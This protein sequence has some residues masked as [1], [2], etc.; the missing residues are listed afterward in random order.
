MIKSEPILPLR[1]YD[2][3]FDQ[4]RFNTH[5]FNQCEVELIYPPTELPSFQ[6]T[7]PSKFQLPTDFIL[8]NVCNDR[9]YSL[10][11]TI[12]ESSS[13]FGTMNEFGS[14]PKDAI[15][16]D[17]SMNLG[18][19]NIIKIDCGKAVS[20][21]LPA[22]YFT[23]TDAKIIFPIEEEQ[24][25]IQFKII[26]DTMVISPGSGF[27][28]QLS[29]N[30]TVFAVITGPGTYIYNIYNGFPTAEITLAIDSYQSGDSF[31]ISYVQATTLGFLTTLFTSD[32]QLTPGDLQVIPMSDGR[33]IISYCKTVQSVNVP[34]GQYYY[35]VLSGSDIYVSEV[36]T[37]KT[38][39]EIESLYKLTW[40]NNCDINNSVI[41]NQRVLN[42]QFK[43]I[44]YLDA[45][46]FKPEYET[47]DE[48]EEDGDGNL[49]TLFKK[50]QKTLEFEIP[51]CPE[52]LADALSAV[53]IHSDVLVKKPL[54]VRQ[55]ILSNEYNIVRVTPDVKNIDGDC[56]QNVTLKLLLSDLYTNTQC[57]T[58]A[59]I[60]SCTPY[61]YNSQSCAGGGAYE[62]VLS[63]PPAVGDGLIKCSDSTL[64]NVKPNDLILHNGKYYYIQYIGG[65]WQATQVMPAIT[66]V[67]LIW[68]VYNIDATIIPYTFATF[69]YQQNGGPWTVLDTV[70]AD[71]TGYVGYAIFAGFVF[72][73][74]SYKIRIHNRT[75]SC[76]YGYSDEW[77]II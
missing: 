25:T 54:N 15:C 5:C 18:P 6:F 44:L 70:Q 45:G 61:K 60:F 76:D 26:I 46:L 7:R 47:K 17:G 3:L 52:F 36:F 10:Y 53:F 33:D 68:I 43:N 50:W 56:F 59:N 39:R 34:P 42:C 13:N 41:Y 14:F 63:T 21:P 71:S 69:E 62:L 40:F 27:N 65:M 75:L 30:G 22:G 74:A 49:N 77:I 16:D 37:I 73:S 12:D 2:D 31:S 23:T 4:F 35:I 58:D 57:C 19:R 32:V 64:V 67:M 72:G 55:Q 29:N 9:N 28:I 1:F 51:K 20:V 24:T 66:G 38:A 8:R 48:G 11:Q